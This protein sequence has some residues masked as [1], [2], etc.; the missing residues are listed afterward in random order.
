MDLAIN[1]TTRDL[2][3]TNG[4]LTFKTGVEACQQ[5]LQVKLLF[6]FKE[7]YLDNTLGLDWFGVAFVKN[8]NLSFIDNMI[9]VAMTEDE[10]VV[11]ILEYST[12]YNVLKRSLSIKMKIQTIYGTI[13]L[14][15][16]VLI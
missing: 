2:A 16:V 9:L 1:L 15:E 11:N 10:E 13:N 8:P 7:W 12:S 5:R 14:S 6:F 4:D 3:F